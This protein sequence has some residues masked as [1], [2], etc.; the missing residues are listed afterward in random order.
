MPSICALIVIG[1]LLTASHELSQPLRGDAA[2]ALYEPVVGRS[3]QN[4]AYSAD[5]RRVLFTIFRNG[6]NNG[7]AGLFVHDRATHEVTTLLDEPDQDSVNLPGT[8]W[9]GPRDLITFSSDREDRHEIWTINAT[10][11]TLRR[12]THGVDGGE[13][14]EP[15]FSPDGEWIVFEVSKPGG[16]KERFGALWKVRNDGTELTRL[17]GGEGA[18]W[19]DRQPNWS[20]RGDR[21]VFQRRPIGGDLWGL[22]TISPEGGA[23]TPI[24]VSAF[25]HSDSTWSPDGK[26]VVFSSDQGGLSNPQIFV[27]SS[28][29]G[30]SARVTFDTNFSDSAPSWSPDG[31]TIAFESHATETSPAMLWEI[32]APRLSPLRR[33]AARR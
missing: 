24:L 16:G 28:Q 25:D 13:S 6:Y 9:N 5:G 12:V 8:S 29:G 30:E 11:G 10:N 2:R 1:A 7:P 32:A 3:A 18:Q 20:P 4:P 15:S 33:R 26:Y 21:I 31:R 22:Y 27:I 23:A 14:I 19:D 17:T